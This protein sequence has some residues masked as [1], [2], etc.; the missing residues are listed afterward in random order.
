[1]SSVVKML[2]GEM[3][4]EKPPNPFGFYDDSP[5]SNV[6]RPLPKFSPAIIEGS[7]GRAEDSTRIT[8]VHSGSSSTSRPPSKIIPND[9]KRES[10]KIDSGNSHPGQNASLQKDDARSSG[11]SSPESTGSVETSISSHFGG[12]SYPSLHSS[13][14]SN[15]GAPQSSERSGAAASRFSNPVGASSTFEGVGLRIREEPPSYEASVMQRFESFENPMAGSGARSFGSRDDEE[16][17]LSENPQCA[18]ALYDFTAG[19]DDEVNLAAG[20]EVEIDYEVDGWFY[21]IPLTSLLQFF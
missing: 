10:I 16:P 18:K 15:Y 2:R 1:M 17:P 3:R 14:P 12:K 6:V 19:G 4:L 11:T 20:E 13:K 8:S 9:L 21:V 7:L 5:E